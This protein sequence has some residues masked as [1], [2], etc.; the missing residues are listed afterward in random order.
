VL[1]VCAERG[2]HEIAKEIV[3]R[4]RENYKSMVFQQI[5]LDADGG[6]NTP[7]HV[8]IEWNSIELVE[9]FLELGGEPLVRI[10]NEE[11]MDALEFAYAENMEEPY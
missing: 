11:G 5:S 7:L 9:Y 1:H 8:A 3:E 6:G 2:F 10:K 4:D